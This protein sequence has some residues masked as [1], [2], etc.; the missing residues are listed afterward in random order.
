MHTCNVM[1]WRLKFKL[2]KRKKFRYLCITST[3]TLYCIT[4]TLGS[5]E[6]FFFLEIRLHFILS[7]LFLLWIMSIF[8]YCIHNDKVC[9]FIILFKKKKKN[10]NRTGHKPCSRFFFVVDIIFAFTIIIISII[11]HRLRWWIE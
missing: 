10:I 11:S 9:N 1:N 6:C 4:L 5:G 3:H 7:N 8:V 2:K